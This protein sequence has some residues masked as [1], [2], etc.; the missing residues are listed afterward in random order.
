MVVFGPLD[1][2]CKEAREGRGS[3]EGKAGE[4]LREGHTQDQQPSVSLT[5]S[6]EKRVE[7]SLQG[8]KGGWE[9]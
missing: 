8:W 6:V 5:R 9:C 2:E 1:S 3:T 7:P 4:T